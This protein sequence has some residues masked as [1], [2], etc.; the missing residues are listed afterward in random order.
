MRTWE[1]T[2]RG[3]W[4]SSLNFSLLDRE[5]AKALHQWGFSG[6]AV[7]L[8]EAERGV[9]RQGSSSAAVRAEVDPRDRVSLSAYVHALQEH[10][11]QRGWLSKAYV[12]WF[13]ECSGR[14]RDL[15]RKRVEQ[16]H[17]AAP[18]LKGLLAAHPDGNL[19][20]RLGLLSMPVAALDQEMVRR[21]RQDGEETWWH[22]C[23]SP[24]AP[25]LTGFVDHYGTAMRLWLWA[26]W[27][28]GLDGIVVW[29][30]NYWHS[31]AV[32]P[33]PRRQNPWDDPMSW[34][35]EDRSRVGA[36]G[37]WGNG[38]GRFLYPPNRD[39]ERNRARILDPAIP[40]IRWELLRD[41]IEDFEYLHLLRQEVDRLMASGV[42]PALW[43][44]AETLL[45]VPDDVYA[46]RTHFAT[47]PGPIHQHRSK[48]AM[49]IERLGD[50]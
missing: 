27:K 20:Q 12:Y 23:N 40:S 8:A 34:G 30:A 6:L 25:Y 4:R 46:D 7:W 48:V 36:R 10:L 35:P 9:P 18:R 33:G 2:A 3:E 44:D 38:D 21:R 14:G 5:V 16:I 19:Y 45:E 42:D 32:Y 41:G 15:V 31:D 47:E 28:Y 26:T 1:E 13:P 29:Q 11:E 22:L 39:P 24:R 37:A 43:R 17:R 49:A 50:L